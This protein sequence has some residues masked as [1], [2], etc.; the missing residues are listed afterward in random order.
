MNIRSLFGILVI[1]LSA[2]SAS[3]TSGECINKNIIVKKG[4]T[5]T[6]IAKRYKCFPNELEALKKQYGNAIQIGQKINI[7]CQC[8]KTVLDE[9]LS[10]LQLTR[11]DL[12]SILQDSPSA[13]V[14][15]IKDTML[16]L[17]VSYIKVKMNQK[18]INIPMANASKVLNKLDKGLLQKDYPNNISRILL[19]DQRG[20]C[21]DA[22]FLI[23]GLRRKQPS[24]PTKK[25]NPPVVN[26][27][28]KPNTQFKTVNPRKNNAPPSQ[29]QQKIIYSPVRLP[30]PA[31][32]ECEP[33]RGRIINRKGKAIPN[34]KVTVLVPN[35]SA[36]EY[37]SIRDRGDVLSHV[38][39]DSNGNF[40][41]NRNLGKDFK[42]SIL[43]EQKGYKYEEYIVDQTKTCLTG[44]IN[45]IIQK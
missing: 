17:P 37:R 4:D 9:N 5:I 22:S 12:D 3:G 42:Y 33:I 31:S 32:Y 43:V 1:F 13:N 40:V 16:E 25:T 29:V 45:I 15:K 11:Q 30:A 35:V 28:N 18:V 7:K 34:A 23:E 21:I 41:I 24:V 20:N 27:Q 10:Q 39:S 36:Y 6:G 2:C 38:N 44:T 26:Y 8:N 14:N 19:C